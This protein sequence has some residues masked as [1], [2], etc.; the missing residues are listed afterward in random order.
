ML[1]T[2]IDSYKAPGAEIFLY[3]LTK[4]RKRDIFSPL[5]NYSQGFYPD[6]IW[7]KGD[8]TISGLKYQMAKNDKFLALNTKGF[9]PFRHYIE[10]L[11]LKIFVN[12]KELQFSHK[13]GNDFFYK[14]SGRIKISEIRIISSTFVPKELGINED[15]RRLGIDVAHITIR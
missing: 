9:H 15:T 14:L 3:N 6:R 11:E 13:K 2:K 8:A 7:T 12:G 4:E 5:L 1:G 10:K